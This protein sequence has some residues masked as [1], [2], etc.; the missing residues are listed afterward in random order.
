MQ[1]VSAAIDALK[2]ATYKSKDE[3]VTTA[4]GELNSVLTILQL[5]SS[6][7]KS[8]NTLSTIF[9]D[10]LTSLYPAF[11]LPMCQ[12]CAVGDYKLQFSWETVQKAVVSSVFDFIEQNPSTSNKDTVAKALYPT[13]CAMFYPPKL[14]LE[15]RSTSLIFN[16]NLLLS[17]TALNHQDNQSRLRSEKLLGPTRLG[18][19]LSQSKGEI[20]FLVLDAVLPLIGVLLPA[21][22]AGNNKRIDF[23]DAVFNPGLFSRSAE[24]KNL[25][26]AWSSSDWDP[27]TAQIIDK[28]LAQSDLSFPQPFS[29]SGLRPSVPI[30]DPLYVDNKALFANI[31][32]DG[33]FDSYQVLFASIERIKISGSGPSFTTVSIQL[34]TEPLIGPGSE[35]DTPDQKKKCTV[36]FQLKKAD[37]ARFVE[38]LKARGLGKLISDTKVSKIAEGLSLEFNSSGKKPST[39]QEKVGKMEQLWQSGRPTS[40]LV[41]DPSKTPGRKHLSS[42]SAANSDLHDASSQHAVT[43]GDDLSDMSDGEEKKPT[44][45]P[46]PKAKPPADQPPRPRKS[47]MKKR[48]VESDDEEAEE[49]KDIQSSPPS[50]ND[51][52][53][54]FEPTQPEAERVPADVP[55]RVTRGAA[56]KNPALAAAAPEEAVASKPAPGR[57]KTAAAT[58]RD[59]DVEAA[60]DVA[61]AVAGRSIRRPAGRKSAAVD[62][63]M[64]LSEDEIEETDSKPSATAVDTKKANGKADLVKVKT[65]TAS[66]STEAK[67]GRKRANADKEE[68]PYS[69]D[70][71]DAEADHRPTKR[72][73]GQRNA[74]PEEPEPIPSARRVSTAVF[75]TVNH[76]P[77]KKRYGGK[78]GRT[79]SPVPDDTDMAIDY[80]ELPAAKVKQEPKTV[81]G[82][83]EARKGRV[84]AMKGKGGQK[85]DVKP[86]PAAKG[87]KTSK[88]APTGKN[89][90][91][92][93]AAAAASVP[94]VNPDEE[95]DGEAKSL[96]RSTRG[97]N[98]VPKSVDP[99]VEANIPKP[100][101]KTKREKP[102][103]APWEDMHLQKNDDVAVTDEPLPQGDAAV[104]D[105]PPT[106]S[107]A[108][109]EYLGSTDP[110]PIP[111]EDVPMLDLTQDTPP[112]ATGKT[113]Q[114][115]NTT[116]ALPAVTSARHLKPPSALVDSASVPVKPAS[117]LT[118]DSASA[119]PVKLTSTLALHA[120][121]P[122]PAVRNKSATVHVDVDLVTPIRPQTHSAKSESALPPPMMKFKSEV[123]PRSI[124]PVSFFQKV[125]SPSPP[126]PQ[127]PVHPEKTPPPAPVYRRQSPHSPA[128]SAQQKVANDSPFPEQAYHTVAFAPPKASSPPVQR[129]AR[130]IPARRMT[131]HTAYEPTPDSER[132]IRP[133]GHAMYKNE[134]DGRDH[135]HKR[136]C[137]PMQNIIEV[138]NEIQEVVL[139]KIT[140]RFDHV[141]N[142]VRIGRDS[143]LCGAA[144]N[145]ESMCAESEG[146][147]N[148]L[149]DLEEEYAA[150]HR[151][152]ILGIDDM[153]KSAE[154]MS[155]T[156][157]QIIQHHDRRSLSKKLPT[158]LFTLPPSLRNP[159]LAL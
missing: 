154:V 72:L 49:I 17:E 140:Q 19:V 101:P 80:D 4:A 95:S 130:S 100:N 129:Y 88:A 31:E 15:W 135:D 26:A 18:R 105:E 38:T 57:T 107:D 61:V 139:E 73:R 39:Q 93:Q 113:V 117:T 136:S 123:P 28:C 22:Q 56:K 69:E 42:P 102:Q 20:H 153:Q 76:V 157:G 158:T 141:R 45:K 112:K 5:S 30:V 120:T 13:L 124:K 109:E 60:D 91:K 14:C 98:A 137:S 106:R 59:P 89:K 145:L 58:T 108:F 41:S 125:A 29:I 64:T 2:K 115:E 65:E 11:L 16:V 114:L 83:I 111:Q 8:H 82:V 143:I 10:K 7:T 81:S 46:T 132:P 110:P 34:I 142:D 119:V 126:T 27:L 62:K 3:A 121:A 9:S 138:L 152:I 33:M 134:A 97:T 66:K 21:R 99:V 90:T 128:P 84:A 156:L 51:K 159:V 63:E 146:H 149:V 54:D 55:T 40:P 48:A 43:Y 96:R 52:D 68:V 12:F 74:A 116:P 1:R 103:K 151:K 75:G 92:T 86:E 150:Y 32:K 79:S 144:A 67:N 23:V 24:I 70:E 122:V 87:P 77:A 36:Q 133:F 148:T 53:Q 25:I 6:S 50:S 71:D 104:Q 155:N 44:S 37:A 127:N 85:P 147:F 118:I 35:I 94:E 47:A 78:K 131:N